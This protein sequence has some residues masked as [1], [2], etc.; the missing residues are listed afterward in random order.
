MTAIIYEVFYFFER[1]YFQ[2]P[3]KFECLMLEIY[4]KYNPVDTRR[5]FNFDT[6]SYD[7]MRRR[8]DV[9]TTS[10][11]YRKPLSNLLNDVLYFSCTSLFKKCAK[12]KRRWYLSEEQKR[13]T[14]YYYHNEVCKWKKGTVFPIKLKLQ[15]SRLNNRI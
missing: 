13:K 6:T 4:S 9:E 5:R 15:E 14:K 10:C 7:V 12:E 8:I 2:K 1:I 11:V 3:L